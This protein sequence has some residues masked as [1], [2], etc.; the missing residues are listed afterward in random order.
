[1]FFADYAKLK[2][3]QHFCIVYD[4]MSGKKLPIWVEKTLTMTSF[5]RDNPSPHFIDC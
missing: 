3:Y 4:Y 2:E 5:Y 1:M